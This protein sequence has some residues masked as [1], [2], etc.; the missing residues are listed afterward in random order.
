V[1]ILIRVTCE[2]GG[3]V[4]FPEQRIE[5]DS[6][7]IGRSETNDVV[8]PDAD[9]R[10]SGSH[11]R[12][13]R[14]GGAYLLTDLKSK[15]GTYVGSNRLTPEKP[16]ELRGGDVFS[17]EGYRIQVV[18]EVAEDLEETL[19]GGKS[20]PGASALIEE[21][22]R[23]YASSVR[24]VED[25]WDDLAKLLRSRL[26]GA[27]SDAV[28]AVCM[29][30]RE[31]F[32][33]EEPAQ[34]PGG[35]ADGGAPGAA[36]GETCYRT[37]A[38]LSRGLVGKGELQRAEDVERFGR[39]LGQA[40]RITVEWVGKCLEGRREFEEQ[41]GA[42]LTVIFS[43]EGNPIK[44]KSSDPEEIGRFLLDWADADE[45]TRKTALEDAFKDLTLHQLGL[46]SGVQGCMKAI[47]EL[48]DPERLLRE[49]SSRPGGVL[50]RLLP[51]L[52]ME[53]RAWRQYVLSHGEMFQENSKLFNELVYPSI[54][55]GY[56]SSHAVAESRATRSG[57]ASPEKREENG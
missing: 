49:A 53:K 51:K 24:P 15:N 52:A 31:R 19:A 29:Q 44:T 41:F 20:V 28:R 37:L 7:L 18:V 14:V 35:G 34:D 39:L 54:R 4:P 2:E 25:R 21:L 22:T 38:E 33:R 1:T 26:A 16:V 45:E 36:L 27:D 5:K 46:I 48:L 50:E 43:K 40:L 42:E 30:V 57:E 9:K 56:L 6:I 10:V 13:D 32:A 11:A 55:K 3:P 23:A 17:I 8:L 47:L 12:L